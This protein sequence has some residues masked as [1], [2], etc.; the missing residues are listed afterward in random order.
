MLKSSEFKPE[1]AF[2]FARQL[3]AEGRLKEARELY[4]ALLAKMPNHPQSLTMMASISYQ[5]G[6]EL[7]AEAY[8]DRSIELYE[9]ALKRLPTIRA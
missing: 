5:E 8:V 7:Q 4:E 6:D 2:N 3:Q 9:E 1:N